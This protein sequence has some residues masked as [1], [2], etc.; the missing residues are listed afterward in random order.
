MEKNYKN[1]KQL[2]ESLLNFKSNVA[3]VQKYIKEK[4]NVDSKFNEDNNTLHLYTNSIN[5]SFNMAQ[6]KEYV[7][8]FI[9]E[10]LL[11]VQY[12]D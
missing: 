10:G 11:Q 8:G 6:A 5:E 9:D 12:G 4:F 2:C 7:D 1:E 3:K